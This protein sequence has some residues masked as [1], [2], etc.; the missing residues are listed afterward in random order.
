M[1][2]NIQKIKL[3]GRDT[4]YYSYIESFVIGHVFQEDDEHIYVKVFEG[5]IHNNMC[6]GSVERIMKI[7]IEKRET[8]LPE[9]NFFGGNIIKE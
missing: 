9:Y 4:E 2:W 6:Y 7:D 5:D 3:K 8:L 1:N